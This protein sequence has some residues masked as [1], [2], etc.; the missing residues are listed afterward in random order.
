MGLGLA[1]N[2]QSA[3]LDSIGSSFNKKPKLVFRWDSHGSFITNT[4]ARM[5]ALGI[6]LRF[7]DYSR[8]GVAV[9]WL[10]SD[11]FRTKIVPT[12][13]G[14]VDTVAAKLNYG[15]FSVY[16]KFVIARIKN[17]SLRYR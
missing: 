3:W 10:N 13:S 8:A 17:G 4:P 7:G 15:M 11:I 14:G 12:D 16:S 2:G 1:V 6:G 9:E 5:T